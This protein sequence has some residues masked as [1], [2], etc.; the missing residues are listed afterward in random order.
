MPSLNVWNPNGIPMI[1]RQRIN[2]A[3]KYSSATKKP[4]NSSQMILPRM[5]IV[6][7][8]VVLSFVLNS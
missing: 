2:P 6:V 5:F 1:V 3:M 7:V 8:V 4:P